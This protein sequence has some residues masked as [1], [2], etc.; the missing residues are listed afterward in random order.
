VKEVVFS[1][2][3][4]NAFKDESPAHQSSKRKS[5]IILDL[6]LSLFALFPL[7]FQFIYKASMSLGD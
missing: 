3:T 4:T 7:V 6:Q 5:S 1:E 2:H